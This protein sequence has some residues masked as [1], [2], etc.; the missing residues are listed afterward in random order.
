MK[1][2]FVIGNPPYQQ[3][4]ESHSDTNGQKPMT[5]I[6]Q[7]FQESADEIS[8]GGTVMIYPGG[9]WIHQSGKG[10]QEFGKKQINDANL[11]SILFYPDASDVFG[12]AASL[13]DGITIV[14]KSKHKQSQG[15]RYI[16]SKGGT[17]KSVMANNPGEKLMPL[18]PYDLPIIQKIDDTIAKKG[19]SYLHDGIL[20]RSLFGIESD[21]VEKN[22]DKVKKYDGTNCNF[23]NGEITL[24]TNDKAGK[25]GRAAWFVADRGIIPHGQELVEQWKVVV[26]SANAGGQKRDNQLEIVDNHSAFG[27]ARLALRSF[28]TEEEAKNFYLYVKTYLIRY[29]FLMTDEALTSLGKEVPDIGNYKSANEIIDFSKDVDEQLFSIFHLTTE[30]KTYIKNTVDNLRRKEMA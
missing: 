15:F 24:L 26:S 19:W 16:Y 6:F 20:P 4:A 2:D 22:P 28:N 8:T 29:A 5:N 17:T 12:N 10:L 14:I 3:E 27:R 7:Y 9:R 1:F 18:N 23:K 13:S 30:E 21:F 25:A 11:V